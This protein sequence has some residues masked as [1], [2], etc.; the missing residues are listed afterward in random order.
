[1]DIAVDALNE[2]RNLLKLA[3]DDVGNRRAIL[4]LSTFEEERDANWQY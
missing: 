3:L 4:H 2:M 1:M